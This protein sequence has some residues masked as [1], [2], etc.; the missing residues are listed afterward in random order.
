MTWDRFVSHVQTWLERHRLLL[1]DARWVVGVS[2]GPDSTVLLRVMLALKEHENLGWSIQAAHLNHGLRGSDADADA[3]FVERLA[4]RLGVAAHSARIDIAGQ[5]GASEEA[6]RRERYAF[7]ERIAVQ[8]GSAY[9]AVG[10]HADDN[11]ETILHRICRG[12]GLRGLA[13]MP[14][15]RPVR[16]G[17]AVQLVRPLLSQRR[18]E[19]EQLCDI[20]EWETRVDSSNLTGQFMRGRIRNSILPALRESINPNVSEALLRLAELDHQIDGDTGIGERL[21]QAGG[22]AG[23]VPD[24]TDADPSGAAIDGDSGHGMLGAGPARR[25]C[26]GRRRR[27]PSRVELLRQGRRRGIQ[28]VGVDHAGDTHFGGGDQ[29]DIDTGVGE[30]PKHAGGVPRTVL[31]ARAGDADLGQL[32]PASY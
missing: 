29:M 1:P 18:A 21:E 25:V 2:G 28:A 24:A 32:E 22:D 20:N 8:T 26:S 12:T 3:A 19:I 30:R 10:H 23:T 6:A 13:G 27:D 5:G 4:D 17:S 7:L 16:P 15:I 31:H 14:G 11:A 9:I